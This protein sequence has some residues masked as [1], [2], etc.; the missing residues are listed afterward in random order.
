MLL[1]GR[2]PRAGEIMKMPHL[3]QTFKVGV[4]IYICKVCVGGGGCLL[5]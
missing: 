2:A 5:V 1:D 4:G 3:A